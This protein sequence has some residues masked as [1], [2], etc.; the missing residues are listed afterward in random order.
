MNEAWDKTQTPSEPINHIIVEMGLAKKPNGTATQINPN[1]N[2]E[3]LKRPTGKTKSSP[4]NFMIPKTPTPT[5]AIT[6]SNN[7]FVIRA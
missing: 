6:K 2:C 3:L 5:N 7:K 4:F 1:F